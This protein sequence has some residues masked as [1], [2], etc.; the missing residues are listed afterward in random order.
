[1][2]VKSRFLPVPK[3]AYAYFNN[4]QYHF[5]QEP[6]VYFHIL[7]SVFKF[8]YNAFK[9]W[10]KKF[11]EIFL[12]MSPFKCDEAAVIWWQGGHVWNYN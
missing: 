9:G 7:K 10:T 12:L 5:V 8:S 6:L 1:M 11:R 2:A 3:A 4:K